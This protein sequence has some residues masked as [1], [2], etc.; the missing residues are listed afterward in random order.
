MQKNILRSI[1]AI[2]IFLLIILTTGQVSAQKS[3][4]GMYYGS[5]DPIHYGHLAVANM[6]AEKL[7]LDKVYLL[8]NISPSHKP[9]ITPF[10]LRYQMVKQVINYEEKLALLPIS[11]MLCF[12][13]NNITGEYHTKRL[14]KAIEI[15]VP[16]AEY[17]HIMG[18]DSFD[19]LDDPGIILDLEGHH[20]VVVN[21]PGFALPK[22]KIETCLLMDN[23]HFLRGQDL[24]ISSSAIR[25]AF[26]SGE[27]PR[28]KLP[29]LIIP[30]IL[31]HNL[32]T[33][34]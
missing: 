6:A 31:E 9:D 29:R 11:A 1:K 16:G 19:R 12:T 21:R 23:F 7:S 32:Y 24:E 34:R 5:F 27:V 3:K 20:L 28:G 8:P 2:L 33:N 17:Y 14:D 25:R 26:S 15:I 30:Y 4:V 18:A 10:P 13:R 22:E